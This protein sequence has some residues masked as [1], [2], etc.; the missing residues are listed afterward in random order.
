MHSNRIN[1][2]AGWL[3]F[4]IA[5][6]SYLLTVL[7]TVGFWDGGEFISSSFKMQVSHPPGAPLY[8]LIT[9]LFT[10]VVPVKYVALMCNIFS[11][12][13]G[14]FTVLILFKVVHLIGEKMIPNDVQ[15]NKI[16]QYANTASA[17]I[18]ALALTYTHT[19][20]TEATEAEVYTFGALFMSVIFWLALKWYE[21]D[22]ETTANRMLMLMCFVIGLS[23]GVH[24]MNMAV[25]FPVVMVYSM[26]KFPLSIKTI[27]FSIIAGLLSFVFMYSVLIQGT[28]KVATW[29]ELIFV[30]GFSLPFHSG[31]ICS[32]IFMIM[33][34]IY[35]CWYTAKHKKINAHY[36]ILG[37]FLFTIG[38]SS[39]AIAI[40]RS[41]YDSPISNNASDALRLLGYLK[42]DQYSVFSDR[43]MISGKF[44]D[45]PIDEKRPFVDGPKIYTR[46]ENLGRYIITNDGKNIKPNYAKKF[47]LFFPRMYN[48][49]PLDEQGY[50]DWG[51]VEGVAINYPVRG[52]LKKII[53][54]T[55]FE[56]L[57]YYFNFQ[58]G[59][60]NMRYLFW[61]YV[62]RQNGDLGKGDP[63]H[64]NWLSG[65]SILDDWRL[66]V[67]NIT[68]KK[69]IQDK[70][71]NVFYGLPFLL[72]IIGLVGLY[73]FEKKLCIIT[74]TFFLML[75]AGLST[76]INQI[77]ADVYARE[78]D[79]IFLGAYFVFSLWIGLS[80]LTLFLKLSKGT[81]KLNHVIILSIVCL[82]A[83]PLQM[84]AKGWN[85][86]DRS[87]DTF[88]RNFGKA[89]L[90]SCGPNSILIVTGDNVM[91]PIWYLQE[92]E[93]Y[94]TDVR[95]INFD[96]LDLDWYIDR[97]KKQ[98]N[99]SPPIKLGL[100]RYMYQKGS[101]N[102]L[103][104]I[105]KNQTNA[106]AELR[107][108]IPF[109]SDKKNHLKVNTRTVPYFPT[110]RFQLTVDTIALRNSGINPE[111][112]MGKF[113]NSM[114]W[115][116]NQRLYTKTHLILYDI[117]AQ[118]YKDRSI[119]FANTGNYQH[120]AGLGPYMV[121]RGLVSQ[122]LPFKPADG[123][124]R[125]KMSDTEFNYEFLMNKV[126]FYE[127]SDNESYI[128]YENRDIAD[129]VL[130]PA[131]YFLAEA[132]IEQGDIER[133]RMVLNRCLEM[134]PNK[135]VPFTERMFDI[136]KSHLR[137]GLNDTGI[138]I[139]N[140]IMTNLSEQVRLYTSFDPIE[141]NIT[142]REANGKL[143]LFGVITDEL[144][145]DRPQ[146]YKTYKEQFDIMNRDFQSW[147]KNNGGPPKY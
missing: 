25:I 6:V 34:M 87:T 68:P 101:E 41:T 140:Q 72:G 43:S 55:F 105:N 92:V 58:L 66:G 76:Y 30:N 62:G 33:L 144:R 56:N 85:D 122:L 89:Y 138:E 102:F 53:K 81:P 120:R 24:I 129:H 93:G 8:T 17:M 14:A 59:W 147:V 104:F 37:I 32:V 130:R 13:S 70:S 39:Y 21:M 11:S 60:L 74:L 145:K 100:P 50:K 77:P 137:A 4:T 42:A 10:M 29:V 146:L 40:I 36:V 133:A 126:D 3:A 132:L 110:D 38:W 54:P 135:T 71:R 88:A 134:M 2:I 31:L 19:F 139:I 124:Y 9:H 128:S 35:L 69:L 65:I 114:Q 23:V 51:R 96:L 141:Y 48:S 52:Q 73:R 98:M 18:G 131:F 1:K 108:L 136:A 44:Y 121:E 82:V 142:F 45:S 118:N 57:T 7:P 28:L 22:D 63:L 80:M 95:I 20:W 91:Y 16:Y 94:R 116:F 125:K 103:N 5:L 84:A 106:F 143:N 46:D 113:M 99:D 90:D 61:N 111:D 123:R 12:L 15:N 78:R 86:H 127:L 49:A 97:L 75:G 115:T 79:Y 109:I 119:Y 83:G 27:V 107:Q 26:K 67:K 47:N 117:L 64:G 112:Y